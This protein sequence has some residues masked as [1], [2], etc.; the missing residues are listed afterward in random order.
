MPY[1]QPDNAN[2]S[3]EKPCIR[4]L[5]RLSVLRS[6]PEGARAAAQRTP[7]GQISFVGDD[8]EARVR[9]EAYPGPAW[10]RLTAIK[11]RHDPINLLRL[12]L[13]IRPA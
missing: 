1:P 11:A 9:G 4:G 8:G 7:A 3:S 6:L 10:E 2:G 12:N 13:N 5:L